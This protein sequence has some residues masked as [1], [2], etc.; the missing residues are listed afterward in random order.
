MSE[1][2]FLWSDVAAVD[3]FQKRR[4]WPTFIG[5]KAHEESSGTLPVF[6]WR[7]QASLVESNKPPSSTDTSRPQ[8]KRKRVHEE[9][10]AIIDD[11]FRTKK[12]RSFASKIF[13]W[14]VGVIQ[15]FLAGI[16]QPKV[17]VPVVEAAPLTISK[18]RTSEELKDIIF[19]DLHDRPYFVG[20]GDVY[21]KYLI[22]L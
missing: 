16:F 15:N 3:F 20:P 2:Q 4:F 22:F 9:S 12:H 10:S 21:G 19:K 11:S 1:H 18:V 14:G 8:L 7:E 6:V 5:A 17:A 13:D